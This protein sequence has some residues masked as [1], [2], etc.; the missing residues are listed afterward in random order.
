MSDVRAIITV[1]L[2]PA[3]DRV[4]EVE[5]FT[6]G[7]HQVGHE[8]MRIP[9]G[10]AVNVSRVL[11]TLGVRNIAT[12]FLGRDNRHE[13]DSVLSGHLV[14]DER[15]ARIHEQL[16]SGW[17]GVLV[18]EIGSD[19]DEDDAEESVWRVVVRYRFIY[20]TSVRNLTEENPE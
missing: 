1:S 5:N 14:G 9:G 15:V 20:R 2:N 4:I 13:F 3:I 16:M 17:P 10:K 11:K 7:E 12:G 6:L 18:E 8:I 19:F